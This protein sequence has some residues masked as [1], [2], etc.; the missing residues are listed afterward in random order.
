M[1]VAQ[2]T[3]HRGSFPEQ[4]SRSTAPFPRL[5]LRLVRGHCDSRFYGYRFSLNGTPLIETAMLKS[6]FSRFGQYRE[7]VFW[8]VRDFNIISKS[9]KVR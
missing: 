2:E 7:I 5:T 4:L 9:W 6:Q 3:T 8:Q 1:D